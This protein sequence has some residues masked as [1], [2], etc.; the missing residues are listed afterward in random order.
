M[1]GEATFTFSFSLGIA[2]YDYSVTAMHSEAPIGSGSGT[3]TSALEDGR[4]TQFAWASGDD[5]VLSDATDPLL[6]EVAQATMQAAASRKR[7]APKPRPAALH[8]QATNWTGYADYF[9][10]ELL[11]P[12]GKF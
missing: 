5:T 4:S 1:Y 8:D 3:Q 10:G 6:I 11:P 12:K 2:D 9:D 7:P